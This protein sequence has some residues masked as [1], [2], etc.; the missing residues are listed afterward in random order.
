MQNY[1]QKSAEPIVVLIS[2]PGSRVRRS[3]RQKPMGLLQNLRRRCN[4]IVGARSFFLN[5]QPQTQGQGG[6]RKGGNVGTSG[7]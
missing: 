7:A 4:L 6:G 5:S 3:P 2:V 1:L